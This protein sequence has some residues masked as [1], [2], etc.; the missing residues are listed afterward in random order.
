MNDE[1]MFITRPNYDDTTSY[2]FHW[3]ENIIEF[4]ENKN[5]NFI[6]FKGERVNKKD[7]EKLIVKQNP[8]LIVFNGHGSDDAIYGHNDETLIKTGENEKI[9]KSKIVYSVTCNSAKK[10]GPETVKSGIRTFI[11]YENPFVFLVDKNKTCTPLL[12]K[13][14]EPFFDSS[15]QLVISLLKSRTTGE[16]YNKSQ[17]TFNKWIEFFQRS[18]APQD[19]LFILRWLIWDRDC[20]KLLGDENSLF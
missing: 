13:V 9:L 8:K 6:D 18:D 2:L 11:G 16:A 4:A 10:L 19:S 1:K 5:I 7:V 20:Q 12:D 17:S 15:N 14:A 3:S